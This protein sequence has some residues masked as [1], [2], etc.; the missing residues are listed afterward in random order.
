M[1]RYLLYVITLNLQTSLLLTS[2]V[3]DRQIYLLGLFATY[4]AFSR[5]T[6]R[7]LS[8]LPQLN[9]SLAGLMLFTKSQIPPALGTY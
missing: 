6:L 9:T 8:M 4:P 3:H 5:L 2:N 1:S 7:L